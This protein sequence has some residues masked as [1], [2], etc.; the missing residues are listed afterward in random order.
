MKIHN[1]IKRTNIVMES[2]DDMFPGIDASAFD[3]IKQTS[4]NS[5]EFR[6]AE[7]SSQLDKLYRLKRHTEKLQSL[8]WIYDKK[9]DAA[10]KH[11]YNKD[12]YVFSPNNKK[13]LG[14]PIV[15]YA[16]FKWLK[17]SGML[18]DLRNHGIDKNS[19]LFKTIEKEIRKLGNIKHRLSYFKDQRS[20][21]DIRHS[22]YA[23][24][25]DE[26]RLDRE[27]AKIAEWDNENT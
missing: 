17:D 1:I 2:E 3:D 10:F 14:P 23:R 12:A 24:W 11:L 22:W 27:R 8:V 5:D 16:D 25:M 19:P 20:D 26:Q 18:V 13:R 6:D 15:Q 7:L 4:P 9:K 21:A